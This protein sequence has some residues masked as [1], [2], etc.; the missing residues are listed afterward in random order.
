MIATDVPTMNTIQ[1]PAPTSHPSTHPSTGTPS[2]EASISPTASNLNGK[3]VQTWN[4]T[5]T[6]VFFGF[7]A[8]GIV[9][10]MY[11]WYKWLST[12]KASDNINVVPVI[13]YIHQVLDL[14]TDLSFCVVLYYQQLYDL[15]IFAGIFILIPYLMSILV[16]VYSIF[17]WTR[18]R[19]DNP[20]RLKHY[21][22][23]Y[24]FVLIL[25]SLFDGFYATI[26]LFRSKILYLR[27][28]YFPLKLSEYNHLKYLRFI[29]FI[30]LENIP[31]FTIQLY[32]L[33]HYNYNNTDD[34][35]DI[36]P[37]VFL[38]ISLTIVSLLFGGIKVG[39]SII[40]ECINSPK[41]T[42]S[43]E[44]TIGGNFI[45]Q[46]KN[47]RSI[48]A[49]C[50]S[51]MQLCMLSILDTCNDRA[52][53]VGRSD[54]YYNIE[55]YHIDCQY[56]LNQL[57]VYFEL[58]VFT[59]NENHK[60]VIHKLRENIVQ[61]LDASLSPNSIHLQLQQVSSIQINKAAIQFFFVFLFL[62]MY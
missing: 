38:S 36:L 25:F 16:S 48:H 30:I 59:M 19:Q 46:Y 43:C 24:E 49:F 39:I 9:V 23:S 52:H 15:T 33:T 8:F 56:Y 27:I 1:A 40:D 47:L 29:N 6:F 42:F 55:C 41:A 20:S 2:V 21:L 62:C 51:R 54:V 34:E 31:Q 45:L 13:R 35:S 14:W 26:D 32:Y 50:H 5:G 53:W 11:V 61:M 10:I 60:I 4:N 37:I 44:T 57:T 18:W 58:K 28:T 22:K 12:H 17:K 3:L 7:I